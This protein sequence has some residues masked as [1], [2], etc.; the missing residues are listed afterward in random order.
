MTGK[1]IKRRQALQKVM[2]LGI[3]ENLWFE[4]AAE[5]PEDAL[6]VV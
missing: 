6:R 2:V 1:G 5:E 4:R 3:R